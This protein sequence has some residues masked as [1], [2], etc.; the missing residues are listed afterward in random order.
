MAEQ[1][2]AYT[3]CKWCH[4][5]VLTLICLFL[6]IMFVVIVLCDV[7]ISDKPIIDVKEDDHQVSFAI[8]ILYSVCSLLMLGLNGFAIYGTLAERPV[9]LMIFAFIQLVVLMVSSMA[10]RP[11]DWQYGV[12]LTMDMFLI[13][14]S[15]FL[16]R[17]MKPTV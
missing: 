7:N 16:A 6:L 4:V 12:T 10:R 14:N 9:I 11:Q 3:T 13:L 1:C 17:S 8:K 2:K 5:V 15:L